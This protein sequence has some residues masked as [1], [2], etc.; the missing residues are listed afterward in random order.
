M[1]ELQ[2]GTGASYI[3]VSAEQFIQYARKDLAEEDA[4]RLPG[5]VRDS[6]ERFVGSLESQAAMIRPR[7]YVFVFDR[8]LFIKIAF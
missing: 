7:H 2:E 1:A 5:E 4:T 6:Y 3:G 8:Y